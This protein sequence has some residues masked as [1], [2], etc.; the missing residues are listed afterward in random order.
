ML[1]DWLIYL[2]YLEDYNCNTTFLRLITPIIFGI[3]ATNYYK[4]NYGSGSGYG[5][6]NGYGFDY[7]SGNGSSYGYGYG[8]GYGSVYSNFYDEEH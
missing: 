8:D 4:Y 1:T 3:T 2:D 5:F 6:G 7:G